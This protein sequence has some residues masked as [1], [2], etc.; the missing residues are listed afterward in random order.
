VPVLLEFRGFFTKGSTDT[1]TK[2]QLCSG[3]GRVEIGEAFSAKVLHL[4][5]EFLE[6]SN[7][8]SELF[9]RGSFGP[10]AR[11]FRCLCSCHGMWEKSSSGFAT[12]QENMGKRAARLTSLEEAI[13]ISD[14]R[15][16]RLR[17]ISQ[18]HSARQRSNPHAVV[19]DATNVPPLPRPVPG[20]APTFRSTTVHRL[21]TT[22]RW[23][24][25]RTE[26]WEAFRYRNSKSLKNWCPRYELNVRQTV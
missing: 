20:S 22:F 7:S 18:A 26:Q 16:E 6:V 3:P 19:V 9:Y 10:H 13:W 11:L 5:E 25:L 21:A 15:Q 12:W 1:L 14:W 4:R 17:R 8:T 24:H 23:A 2:L